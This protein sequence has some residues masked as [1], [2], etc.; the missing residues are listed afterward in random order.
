MFYIFQPLHHLNRISQWVKNHDGH[1]HVSADTFALSIHIGSRVVRLHPRFSTKI[2]GKISYTRQFDGK[3]AFIGWVPESLETWTE[4]LD[5][6]QFKLTANKLRLRVPAGWN[7][8]DFLTED[9]LIKTRTGSFGENIFGPFKASQIKKPLEGANQF[10][11]QFIPGRSMKVWCW[12]QHVVAAEIVEPPYLIG[13]GQK[14]I[15][16]LAQYR[17]SSVDKVL[18]L[19]NSAD[20]LAWQ[21]KT[22]DSIPESEER[23]WID[24]KYVT[25]FDNVTFQDR[26]GWASCSPS[27]RH[28]VSHAAA[29]LYQ[30]ISPNNGHKLFTIDAVVDSQ[31]RVWLL[32]MN[33]HPMIHP[34]IYAAMLPDV[35]RFLV[36]Q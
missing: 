18:S 2:S 25:P 30:H 1:V 13:D 34:N 35:C 20:V 8:G 14:T 28:Q 24:F 11:E 27:V 31:E 6:A 19:E 32:E 22:L 17:R 12:N 9:Y 23:I 36:R 15:R 29:S 16:E 21:G 3:G 10:Y 26:D 7:T 4:S 33:S 5:K